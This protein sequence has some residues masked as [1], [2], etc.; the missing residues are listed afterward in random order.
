MYSR[1][2]GQRYISSYDGWFL[3]IIHLHTNIQQDL[4]RWLIITTT[5]KFGF[6]FIFFHL[7]LCRNWRSNSV[8]KYRQ[9]YSFFSHLCISLSP[10][11]AS[12]LVLAELNQAC[13][14]W[15][16][17]RRRQR[18]TCRCIGME[19]N[20][21][22]HNFHNLKE[23]LTMVVVLSTRQL[24]LWARALATTNKIFL[25]A[26]HFCFQAGRNWKRT[27]KIWGPALDYRPHGK[28]HFLFPCGHINLTAWDNLHY[29]VRST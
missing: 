21:Q 18:P 2:I 25:D 19:T 8:L 6:H 4:W 27:K 15:R 23:K 17:R 29:P 20:L 1:L 14:G 12:L 13:G 7:L 26:R 24:P 28:M 9:Q 3:F 11:G 16:S 5:S 10:S 22:I